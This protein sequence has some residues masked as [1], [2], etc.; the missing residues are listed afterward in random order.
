MCDF[1]LAEY[2]RQTQ[3]LLRI[4]C[5]GNTRSGPV[6]V[7]PGE[8]TFS[9]SEYSALRAVISKHQGLPIP[10]MIWKQ[11]KKQV[12]ALLFI[13][14]M[15]PPG[16]PSARLHPRRARFRFARQDHC[17][18]ATTCRFSTSDGP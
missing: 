13:I 14:S 7:Q 12:P 11:R 15:S 9:V 3:Y 6:L 4:R 17:S 8:V 1:F 18:S 16:Y 2:L 5:L 10:M